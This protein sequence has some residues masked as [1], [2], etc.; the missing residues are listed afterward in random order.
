MD[1][2]GSGRLDAQINRRTEGLF[3]LSDDIGL[4]Q[5]IDATEDDSVLWSCYSHLK[6]AL[7]D[8]GA[9]ADLI[10]SLP[11]RALQQAAVAVAHLLRSDSRGAAAKGKSPKGGKA[12]KKKKK[13]KR[14][15]R[16]SDVDDSESDDTS[17]D[18]DYEGWLRRTLS[19][20]VVL[21]ETMREQSISLHRLACM[22]PML[23]QMYRS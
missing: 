18:S 16:L 11:Y 8:E 5:P 13:K 4:K 17:D 1:A 2:P 6:A 15:K 3:K 9:Q 23:F 14:R 22:R 20:P 10:S 21:D 19:H 12:A 7:K